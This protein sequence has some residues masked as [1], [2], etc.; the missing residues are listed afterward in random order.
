[1]PFI[2]KYTQC[3]CSCDCLKWR[4]ACRKRFGFLL[5][6][7]IRE[8][9]RYLCQLHFFFFFCFCFS[10][11]VKVIKV[12]KKHITV[13]S[14]MLVEIWLCGLQEQSFCIEQYFLPHQVNTPWILALHFHKCK[15]IFKPYWDRLGEADWRDVNLM[16]MEALLM[17]IYLL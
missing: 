4:K 8:A 12:S 10:K 3:S 2:I 5:A 16:W 17:L 9:F 11:K 13:M 15:N 14:W 1:M 6:G 7:K